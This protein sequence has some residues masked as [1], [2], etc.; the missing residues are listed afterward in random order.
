MYRRKLFR[1]STA[2]ASL[3]CCSILFY[4]DFLPWEDPH[5]ASKKFKK[6][7][8]RLLRTFARN[9]QSLGLS[10]GKVQMP[11]KSAVQ[12]PLQLFGLYLAWSESALAVGL[13]ATTGIDHWVKYFLMFAMGAGIIAYV[14]VAGFLLV[15]LVM[16]R[17]HFLFN[18]SDYDKAVQPMLF[19]QPESQIDVNLAPGGEEK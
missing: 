13:L 6:F 8:K 11:S 1:M 17:P 3:N 2:S 19:N 7:G 14:G 12:S 18:P 10:F 5:S 4:Q 9:I 16:K 15:Y